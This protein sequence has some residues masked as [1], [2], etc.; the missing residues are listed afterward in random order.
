M[1]P[2]NAVAGSA[3]TSSPL[4]PFVEVSAIAVVESV[5]KVYRITRLGAGA[6]L[7]VPL[8]ARRAIALTEATASIF[9]IRMGKI[10]VLVADSSSHPPSTGQEG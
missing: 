3:F 1:P 9:E 10:T 4:I 2:V 6:A 7:E 8:G 5:L